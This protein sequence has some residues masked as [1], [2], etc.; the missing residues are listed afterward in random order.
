[1]DAA[2]RHRPTREQLQPEESLCQYCPAKCCHYF[3][4]PIDTPTRRKDFDYIRWYLLHQGAT[5]FTEG[6]TWYLL[7][8]S[9]CRHLQADHRCGIYTTRPQI[10]REYST[11]KCEYDDDWVYERYFETPEQVEEYAEMVLPRRRGQSIRSPQPAC[12][13]VLS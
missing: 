1:M 12:L 5:V 6:D 9:T 13:P 4:L 7:V 3:A 8:Y 2:L 11:D 10:C